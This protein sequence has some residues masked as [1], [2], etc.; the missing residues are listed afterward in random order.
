MRQIVMLEKA[1]Q[2][3]MMNGELVEVSTP[4]GTLF[5]GM[6][7][8]DAVELKRHRRTTKTKSSLKVKKHRNG[9]GHCDKCNR[10]YK[11]LELHNKTTS[12][13]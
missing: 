13:H 4:V 9:A 2:E 11:N 7:L 1:E 10:D 8:V 6:D 12:K 3:Q 5:I